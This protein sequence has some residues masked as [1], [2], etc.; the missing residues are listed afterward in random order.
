[1][2][3]NLSH[4]P[5]NVT[6]FLP[7]ARNRVVMRF[8][9]HAKF[10]TFCPILSHFVQFVTNFVTSCWICHISYRFGVFVM[11]NLS[12]LLVICHISYRYSVFVMT[13]WFV[14][15]FVTC[16]KN[17][18]TSTWKMWQMWQIHLMLWQKLSQC[19]P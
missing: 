14:T 3:Q 13:N 7:S 8:V 9:R 2:W 17:F 4:P 10:V 12:H 19:T 15:Y 16:V 5:K 1:M 6:K 18:V 11:T